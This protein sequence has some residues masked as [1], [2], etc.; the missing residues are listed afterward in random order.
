MKYRRLVSLAL[1][2]AFAAACLPL[3]RV[4]A[5]AEE[6]AGETRAFL[7]NDDGSE[8]ELSVEELAA[9]REQSVSEVPEEATTFSTPD[10]CMEI[11]SV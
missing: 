2:L 4:A 5:F 10:S 3:A 6:S 7:V 11:T 1:V 9:L 8:I